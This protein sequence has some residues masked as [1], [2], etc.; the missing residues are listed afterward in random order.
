MS[1]PVKSVEMTEQRKRFLH[2]MFTTAIEGGIGYWSVVDTYKWWK[3][4]EGVEDL[5]DFY[6][7][8]DSN[9][10]D[11]GVEA[12]YQPNMSGMPHPVF[13][14]E[15]HMI[16]IEEH[17]PLRIDRQVIERGWNLFMDK[18]I[19]AAKSEDPDAP[20]SRRYFRQAVIQYLTDCEDG[21][22]DA[23]V[24]DLVVQYGLFGE[25]VYG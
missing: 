12:A 24:A 21:D 22:S 18:V 9:E 20:C 5:D 4:P 15:E 16:T 8:I 11:W 13:K 7:V 1:A 2:M 19:E 14:V 10:D 25:H 23:D 6:A 17:M 3:D